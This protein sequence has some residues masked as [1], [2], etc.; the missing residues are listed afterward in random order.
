MY[1]THTKL[2][3]IGLEHLCDMTNGAGIKRAVLSVKNAIF[4]SYL[5]EWNKS[6]SR[7]ES[8]R[9][10]GGNKLRVYKTFKQEFG[11]EPYNETNIP[12]SHRRALALF[13]CT[14]TR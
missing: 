9:G 12:R 7:T 1:R 10:Q 2:K 11:V 3:S 8:I 4:Q 6:I 5:T 13:R 14:L